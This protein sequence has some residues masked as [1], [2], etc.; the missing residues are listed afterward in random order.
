MT[1]TVA[2]KAGARYAASAYQSPLR[3]HMIIPLSGAF[4]VSRGGANGVGGGGPGGNMQT[5]VLGAQRHQ[6][7]GYG[8]VSLSQGVSGGGMMGGGPFRAFRSGNRSSD[9]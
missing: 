2:T 6:S 1:M 7:M 8:M 9:L 3:V 5:P 4:N